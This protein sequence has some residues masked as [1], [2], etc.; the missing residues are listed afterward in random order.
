MKITGSTEA[1]A[2]L[3]PMFQ[4]WAGRGLDVEVRD[5]YRIQNH[6]R[7]KQC[8]MIKDHTDAGASASSAEVAWLFHGSAKEGVEGIVLNDR[9]GF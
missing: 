5:V 8:Q 3:A 1:D 2:V 7:W 9:E 6:L 4:S